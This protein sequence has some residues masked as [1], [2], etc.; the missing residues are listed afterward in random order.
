MIVGMYQVRSLN[1]V[2]Q[3]CMWTS[4]F[5]HG[6]SFTK[7][8]DLLPAYLSRSSQRKRNNV[9]SG[10][11]LLSFDEMNAMTEILGQMQKVDEMG[12]CSVGH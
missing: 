3:G 8:A 1:N 7:N 10:H 9:D 12:L 11:K 5:G 6:K 2:V 4:K